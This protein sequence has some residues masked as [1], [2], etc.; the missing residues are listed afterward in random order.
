MNRNKLIIILLVNLLSV[1]VYAQTT[2]AQPTDSTTT[3]SKFM[4]DAGVDILNNF[5]WRG[6][7]LDQGPNLQPTLI[8][9]YGNLKIS[10]L[11]SYSLKYNFNNIMTLLTYDIPTSIGT[12]T[13]SA[14]HY[15]YPYDPVKLSDYRAHDGSFS[16]TTEAGIQYLG[17]KVPLRLY[18]SVNIANDSDNSTYFEAG[19]KF[20][21]QGIGVEPFVGAVF[22]ASPA[23]H[24]ATKA[25]LLNVGFNASKK[26]KVSDNYSL[27]LTGTLSYHMQLDMLN[28][29]VRLSVF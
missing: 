3:K 10:F 5:I 8:L 19:Y 6:V 27:P 16:H 15:Y 26:I 29:M 24:A 1:A 28:V 18:T 2:D 22:N 13:P 9:G 14:I 21:V 20:D 17:T 25:G 4:A 11:G 12:F 7:P 23:W